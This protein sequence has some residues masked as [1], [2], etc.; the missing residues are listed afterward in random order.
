MEIIKEGRI[1]QKKVGEPRSYKAKCSNCGCVFVFDKNE[2]EE[3]W[4][5]LG[6]QG[7]RNPD[8]NFFIHCPKCNNVIY[9]GSWKV[10]RQKKTQA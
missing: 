5:D 10:L 7:G 4:C 6:G 9:N 3:S 2:A 1:P 8:E